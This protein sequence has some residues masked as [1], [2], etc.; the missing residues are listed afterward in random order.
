VGTLLEGFRGAAPSDMAALVNA[1]V[2]LSTY[3]AANAGRMLEVEI[4][5]FVVLPQGR[6]AMGVDALLILRPPEA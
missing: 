4:N 1:L 3:A 5:P 6:G 2:A